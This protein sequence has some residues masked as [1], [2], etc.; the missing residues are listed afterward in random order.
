MFELLV[1]FVAHVAHALE[2]LARRL[3]AAF[4]FLAA[5]LVLGDAGGFFEMLAQLL[6]SA[7]TICADHA[8]LD[9]RV[10][11]RAQAGAE[12]QIGDVAAPAAHAVE[13]IL[14]L[15]RRG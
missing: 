7:S 12:E 14:R 9:D 13:E 4:G 1:D 2:I 5:F 15:R 6:G 11:A 8:L 3:D 10:A